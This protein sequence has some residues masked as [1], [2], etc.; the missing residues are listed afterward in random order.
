MYS[1]KGCH[2]FLV[3]M[4]FLVCHPFDGTYFEILQKNIF[5]KFSI[6]WDKGQGKGQG[7]KI[8]AKAT[9]YA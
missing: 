9:S 5:F 3:Q 1:D 8:K 4:D 6:H 7:H 2:S